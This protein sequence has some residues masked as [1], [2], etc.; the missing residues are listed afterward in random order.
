MTRRRDPVG[1]A[2]RRY[3]AFL[4]LFPRHYVDDAAD[5]LCQL[6][7]DEYRDAKRAGGPAVSGLWLRVAL[8]TAVSLPGVWWTCLVEDGRGEMTGLM[9][10]VRGAC[11]GLARRPGFAVAVT[12]TLGLG[13]GATTTIL[14]VVDGV[15]IRPLPY[16]EAATL[17][18]VGATDPTRE[19]GDTDGL[20][21][22]ERLSVPGYQ[23]LRERS[24]SLSGLAALEPMSVFLADDGDGPEEI[25]SAR[26]S[27]ELFE[28]LD[29]SPELGR[30]FLPEEHRVGAEGAVMISYGAWQRRYGGDPDVVGR[31]EPRFYQPTTIVGV[32]PRDFRP[33]EAFFAEGALPDFWLPLQAAHDRYRNNWPALWAIGRLTAS[34][35]VDR[36]R[37]DATAV[38]S[39]LAAELPDVNVLPDGSHTGFGINPLRDQ[40]VGATGGTLGIFLGAAALL[41]LLAC[42]NTATLFLARLLDR[43]GELGVRVALGGGGVR[44]VR[45]LVVEACVVAAIAGAV[46]AMLAY[47]GVALFLRFAPPSMPSLSSVVVDGRILAATAVLSLGAGLA[48]G[49]VPALRLLR[50]SPWER[51]GSA[52]RTTEPLAGLRSLLVGGQMAVAVVLLSGASLLFASFSEIRSADPGFEP[53]GLVTLGVGIEGALRSSP[54]GAINTV[55]DAWDL[56]L[57]RI[58]AVPGVDAVA[59]ATSVPFKAPSWTPRLLLEGDAPGTWR[60]GIAGYAVTPD[61]FATLGIPLLSGRGFDG[62]DGPT[63]EPVAIV[64]ESFVRTQLDGREPLGTVV[65]RSDT[66]LETELRIVGV[67]ADAVQARVEDGPRPAVYIPYTQFKGA[68]QAIVRTPLPAGAIATDLRRAVAEFN[69]IEP[70][71]DMM[72]MRERM[73]AT[74]ANP[75]F[76]AVLVASFAIVAVLLAAAGLYGSL[77]HWVGRRR[78]ELGLRMAI[79]ADRGAVRRM[80]LGEGMLV[81]CAGLALGVVGA[82]LSGRVLAGLL[83]GVRPSDPVL[84]ASAVATLLLVAAAASFVP[85][86]R[87]TSVDPVT[88]LKSE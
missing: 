81:A 67:S 46:G 3:R 6:F 62:S 35:S 31:V 30:T 14:S 56:A 7:E 39:A 37:E 34:A 13:I 10:D 87:A 17:V 74:R 47:G 65:R 24:R 63:T 32:L 82:L 51:L 41:L 11:R 72:T 71:R 16:E 59:G 42:M 48:A 49:L 85:A 12:L 76:Q 64:N 78:R 36:A 20:L 5:E 54:P 79:G 29:V 80:V 18:A 70:V 50:R 84:L 33:P 44:I 19:T 69:P 66:L 57:E 68:L 77:A 9:G 73:G 38:A 60:D 53:D 27:S 21:E 8:D 43:S 25:S 4:R 1:R 75:R 55:S 2:A 15:M 58:A 23:A 88:V 45:L 86:R 22:L 40:T 28:I 61:Y 83:Y 26:A 52:G